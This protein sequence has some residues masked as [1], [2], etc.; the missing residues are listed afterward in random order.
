LAVPDA[1]GT[2]GVG[3][4]IITRAE[5][6]TTPGFR[7]Q[8]GPP[9]FP[10]VEST[11]RGSTHDH[12]LEIHER[13]EPEVRGAAMQQVSCAGADFHPSER[14]E[15]ARIFIRDRDR[16]HERLV[17]ATGAIGDAEELMRIVRLR[18]TRRAT[19]LTHFALVSVHIST[20]R[21]QYF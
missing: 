16:R 20:S 2:E 4:K 19:S 12:R 6:R 5:R 10:I 18:R 17:E 15:A 11:T 21:R 1:Q 14:S 7:T 3:F 8:T 9:S 13:T